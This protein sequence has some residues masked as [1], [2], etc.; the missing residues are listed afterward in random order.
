MRKR[1]K[2]IATSILS[3][4]IIAIIGTL[5]FLG[6]QSTKEKELPDILEVKDYHDYTEEEMEQIFFQSEYSNVGTYLSKLSEEEQKDIKKKFSYLTE[7]RVKVYYKTDS[8]ETDYYTT[9]P[10][11]FPMV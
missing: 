10:W 3:L 2:I 4:C 1:T 11:K 9:T 8:G 5:F 7:K 6:N